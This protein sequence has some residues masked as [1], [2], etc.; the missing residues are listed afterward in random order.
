MTKTGW[1]LALVSLIIIIAGITLFVLPGKTNAPTTTNQATTTLQADTRPQIPG[2]VVVESLK[3]GDRISSPLT[4]TGTAKGWYFEASFP[5]EVRNASGTVIAIGPATA[6]SDWMV[7]AFVPFTITLTFPAQPTGSA[8]SVIL[9]NDNPSGLPENDE[10]LTIP[11][12]F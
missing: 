8:G 11:V 10:S 3:Y 5:I 12:V 6:Q 2:R 1:A 4:I 9:R 7:D